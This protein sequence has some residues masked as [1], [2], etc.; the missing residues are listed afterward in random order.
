MTIEKLRALCLSFPGGT[1]QIQWGYD[2]VFKVGGKM[3]CVTPTEPAP[4]M[5]SFKCDDDVFAELVEREGV[6]PAPYLARAKW[7]ALERFDTIAD[8]ELVPLVTRAY[9]IVRD[10]LPKKTIAMLSKPKT[11]AKAAP[12]PRRVRR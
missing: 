4:V 1:E 12:K 6:I 11:K 3:F 2:L 9:E 8:R 7:V 5:L 10:K